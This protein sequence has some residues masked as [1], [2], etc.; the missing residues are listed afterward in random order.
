MT[1]A[2][3]V[4][5]KN[6]IR[7]DFS[8]LVYREDAWWIAHCLEMDLPAE[9]NT[10]VEAVQNL[11]DLANLQVSTALDEGNLASIF[12]PA[13]PELWRSFATAGLRRVTGFEHSRI[14]HGAK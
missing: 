12:L 8:I 14:R 10:P 4:S 3:R 6:R 11:L 13:P 2:T 5:S 1:R 7:L 9:G